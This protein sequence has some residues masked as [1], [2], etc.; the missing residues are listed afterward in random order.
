MTQ[1]V[2]KE[3][4]TL[5]GLMAQRVRM[6][7]GQLYTLIIAAALVILLTLTG[8]PGAHRPATTSTRPAPTASTP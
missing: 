8:L 4:P 1:E 7:E 5:V 6:T 3:D 2:T